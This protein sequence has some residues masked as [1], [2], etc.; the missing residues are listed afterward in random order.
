MKKIFVGIIIILVLVLL[1][2]FVN[3]LRN[4]SSPHLEGKSA[5]TPT[6][7]LN[8]NNMNHKF[9]SFCWNED[10][11]QKKHNPPSVAINYVKNGDVI[12]ID[13]NKFKT[14]PN[15]VI[16]YN[17]TTD[18]IIAYHLKDSDIEIDISKQAHSKP[19]EYE[20]IFQ[21]YLGKS[22]ELTGES[23]LT[24]KVKAN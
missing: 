15:R 23:F 20:V 7:T 21:W 11:S 18:E 16:L 8:G 3:S 19:I 10:C 6:I 24:F 5:P 1:F 4:L 9:E 14:K 2:I 12:E 13:W 17:I 22:S